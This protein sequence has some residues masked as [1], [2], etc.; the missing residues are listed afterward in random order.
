MNVF[1]SFYEKFVLIPKEFSQSVADKDR[2]VFRHLSVIEILFS[3][4]VFPVVLVV[5]RLLHVDTRT[6]IYIYYAIIFLLGV[7]GLI[8]VKAK[9]PSSISNCVALVSAE[10]ILCL[11]L[12]DTPLTNSIIIFVSLMLILVMFIQINPV[13]FS[14]ELIIFFG[15]LSILRNCEIWK[16]SFENNLPLF[17]NSIFLLF[18]LIILVF[19]KRT[20]LINELKRDQHLQNQKIKTEGLLHNLLPD[21]V[22]NLLKNGGTVP[23]QKYDNMTVLLSDIVGFTKISTTVEPYILISELNDIFTEFDK[24]TE[25]H[26][27][28]RIKTIGDAYMAVCGLPEKNNKHAENLILC[29]NDFITYLTKRNKTSENQWNIRIGLAS[30]S[31][32]AG[33]IGKK[34][35]LYDILGKTVEY[36]VKLQNSCSAMHIKI[37]Q[38][39]YKLVKDKM[40]LPEIVEI[41]NQLPENPD[42]KEGE[43]TKMTE[44]D[45]QKGDILLYSTKEKPKFILPKNKEELKDC[46]VDNFFILIDRLIIFAEEGSTTT[47]AALAYDFITDDNGEKKCVVAEATLPYCRKRTPAF[48]TEDEILTVHRLPAG[49]DG[50]PVLDELPDFV[51]DDKKNNG[52]AMAQAVVAALVCLFRTRVADNHEKAEKLMIF[53]KF[54]GYA[55]AKWVEPLFPFNQGGKTPFFC[56]Q[57]AAY[58]YDMTALRL[59]DERYRVKTP[60]NSKIGDTLID[61]LI[62]NDIASVMPENVSDAIGENQI[63]LFGPEV[64]YSLCD[65]IGEDT[66]DAFEGVFENKQPPVLYSKIKSNS[67]GITSLLPSVKSLLI[68]IMKI[69]GKNVDGSKEEFAKE[70]I[71]FQTSF[72]MPS[73]L[74]HVFETV[75]EMTHD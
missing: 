52:Y 42:A 55:I 53:L 30:G 61:Y 68:T 60:A 3:L 9:I 15:S 40:A 71:D 43:I 74:E 73:D 29:A 34:K 27:C 12:F 14:I 67:D 51:D 75:G 66:F 38:E 57:L 7:T 35:Y 10:I 31:A 13:V 20:H 36:A 11:N 17:F 19:W 45:L 37:S 62:K 65:I 32:I 26:H 24:I 56:S 5:N 25:S 44:A 70:L 39:T 50:A 54:L 33:I 41:D 16:I 69:F 59:H 21:S 49:V 58:C 4:I 28:I 6:I 47:H 64:L 8:L 18:E 48:D 23:P 2:K 63:E 22:I 72:I 46:I 1:K